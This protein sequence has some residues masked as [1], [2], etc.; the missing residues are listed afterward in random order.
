MITAT[1]SDPSHDVKINVH[2]AA[3]AAQQRLCYRVWRQQDPGSAMAR[4]V[5]VAAVERCVSKDRRRGKGSVFEKG[6]KPDRQLG[7]RKL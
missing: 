4:A 5:A 7:R 1:R 3:N 2:D 6:G